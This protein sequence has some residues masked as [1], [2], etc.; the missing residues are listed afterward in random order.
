M[1]AR[2]FVVVVHDLD[3]CENRIR[4][5][6]GVKCAVVADVGVG[7]SDGWVARAGCEARIGDDT[8]SSMHHH[9]RNPYLSVGS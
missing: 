3:E 8:A 5:A 7:G 9:V 1:C 4:C 2:F 6:V